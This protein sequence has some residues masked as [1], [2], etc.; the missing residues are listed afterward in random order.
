MW[1]Q[2]PGIAEGGGFRH[3]DIR[4][5]HVCSERDRDRAAA[6]LA[7]ESYPQHPS[8]SLPTLS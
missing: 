7:S 5:L 4:A 6:V 2:N 1:E 8:M 3:K